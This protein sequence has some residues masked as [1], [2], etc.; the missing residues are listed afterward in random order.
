MRTLGQ[1]LTAAGQHG[2]ALLVLSLVLGAAIPPLATGAYQLLPLS[3]FLLT[4]GSF[5]TAGF[6]PPERVVGWRPVLVAVAWVGLGVPLTAAVLLAVLPL[7]PALHAGVLLSVL[8]PPVGSAAAIAAMLGLQPRLALLTSIALTLVAPL[9]MPGFALVLGTEVMIDTGQLALRLALI[10]GSAAAL[11]QMARHW[12]KHVQTVLPD[13][14]AG[15]GVAVVGLVIVGLAMMSGIRAHW[16]TDPDAFTAFVAAAVGVNLGAGLLGTMLF[17]SWGGKNALTVGLV[18]G[19][20]NV[21]LAW[22]AAGSTLPLATEAYVAACVLPVLALPLSVKTVIALRTRLREFTSRK[23]KDT[24]AP[25]G[26]IDGR[27]GRL[28]TARAWCSRQPS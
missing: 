16:T 27:S 22:A 14:R 25:S 26:L 23:I 18:S 7:D 4:F 12:R 3:A 8:A 17:W 1:G 10:I 20:R 2:P 11:A 24:R 6:A 15:A 9:S 13:Q 19:N 5:L 21:T 28:R